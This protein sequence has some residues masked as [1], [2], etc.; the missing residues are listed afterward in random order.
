MSDVEP[1]GEYEAEPRPPAV[2][3]ALLQGKRPLWRVVFLL[4]L[5]VMGQQFLHLAVNLSDRLLAGRFLRLSPEQLQEAERHEAAAAAMMDEV[6]LSGTLAAERHASAA[7]AIRQ[8]PITYQSALTT[9][10]YLTWFISSFSVLVTV[11]ATAVV[12]RHTGAKDLPG[13]IRAAKQSLLLAVI[14][15]AGG[16]AVGLW[17]VPHLVWI[18]QLRGEAAE[19]AVAYLTPIF[20]VLVLQ[21]IESVGIACL[22]GAGDTLTGMFVLAGVAVC[23]VPISWCLC[24]GIGPFPEMGFVGIAVGTAICHALA[25]LAVLLLL[26]GGRAG[27]KIT[28]T[29]FRPDATLMRRILRVSLPA[30]FDSLSIVLWQFWFLGI[31]NGLGTTASA[32]H[33]IALQWEALGYLSGSAF[34]AAAMALVGQCLGAQRPDLA[35]R[36]AWTAFGLGLGVMSVM[37]AVFFLLAE[38]MFLLFCPHPEQRPIV[39]QGVP[40]LQLIAFGMPPL[41]S[42]IIFTGALRG[43][44]DTRVPVLFTW[45]GFLGVR[46][47]LAYL[48][49]GWAGW[50]LFGA[51]CA[52]LAD[53]VV[54]G[55]AFYWRFLGGAWKSIRV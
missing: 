1:Q 45:M 49:A 53:L 34:A 21:M 47:P 22:V 11:G 54:R 28:A 31:V 18:L 14:F 25:G 26:C 29:K 33:G 9:A 15:G 30:G 16:S 41:A 23:N 51:W 32:A 39:Q 4:T 43:A 3:P 55:A 52:M 36:S 10:G 40:V 35:S 48:L 46:I 12:A 27:L 37:G 6:S 17:F 5:P 42:C 20:C 7:A 19:L 44:G 2:P 8:L 50:G 13:A 38:P 24:L